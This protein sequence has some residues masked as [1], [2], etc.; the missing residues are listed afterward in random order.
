MPVLDESS[1]FLI[2][3]QGYLPY[4]LSPGNLEPS[5]SLEL[6]FRRGL[7]EPMWAQRPSVW[8]RFLVWGLW[9]VPKT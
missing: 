9:I 3:F 4:S 8:S 6:G 7:E 2:P 1:G 5:T